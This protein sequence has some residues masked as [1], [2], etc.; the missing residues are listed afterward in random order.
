[1][2]KMNVAR[3]HPLNF[4]VCE[5]C[6]CHHNLSITKQC[7]FVFPLYHTLKRQPLSKKLEMI[8]EFQVKKNYVFKPE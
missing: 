2:S 3:Y 4:K 5:V 1:M 8:Q 6:Y 7:L